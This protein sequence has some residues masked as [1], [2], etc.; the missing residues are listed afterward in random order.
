M[1]EQ[2]REA[3]VR[4]QAYIVFFCM[5]LLSAFRADKA[6]TEK[7]EQKTHGL[8]MT[9]YRRELERSNR[10]KVAVFSG[11]HFG[12]FRIFEFGLLAGIRIREREILGDTTDSVLSRYGVV[13]P[14]PDAI[15]S[16]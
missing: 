4:V 15:N 8:G 3:G 2:L 7:A 10:D 9:R 5:A 16:S 14:P 6:K 1:L 11:R 13:R 12:I